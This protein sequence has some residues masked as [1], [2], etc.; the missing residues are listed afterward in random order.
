MMYPATVQ[1]VVLT[2]FVLNRKGVMTGGMSVAPSQFRW[3]LLIATLVKTMAVLSRLRRVA[4]VE[5]VG[6]RATFWC[7]H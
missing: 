4:A 2:G 3:G 1:L 7:R 6:V 5:E